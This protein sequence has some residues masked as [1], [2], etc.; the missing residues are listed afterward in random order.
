VL[1]ALL[2][3][4]IQAAREAARRM[5]CTNN[6]KQVG[7]ALLNYEAA[8]GC[9]PIVGD[10]QTY[11]RHMGSWWVRILP[12]LESDSTCD[13]LD[14]HELCTVN[15]PHNKEFL[16][17]RMFSYMDCP[18][19]TLPDF[20]AYSNV[21]GPCYAA[22]CGAV[23]H[24]S[25]RSAGSGVGLFSQGGVLTITDRVSMKDITDGTSSTMMVGEQSGWC[26]DASAAERDCRSCSVFG[27][28]LG[29]AAREWPGLVRA[30]NY[31]TV[32][33]RINE[34][35][36]EKEG[37]NDSLPVYAY[38][39]NRPIQSEHPGGANALFTDGSVHFLEETIELQPLYDLANRDDGHVVRIED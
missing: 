34:R 27:F 8:N 9:F 5:S 1:V 2:L 12:Q 30:F 31:T 26:Y 18:S 29:P 7:L 6:L 39:A 17:H 15:N 20:T 14:M 11:R 38:G 23:D 28:S 21:M 25:T 4:A 16:D 37:I 24:D 32:R 35:D 13:N 19:S 3:P 36:W 22:I 33:Y 10:D